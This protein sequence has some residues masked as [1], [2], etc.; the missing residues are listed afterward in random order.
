V[1]EDED[2]ED[3][4]EDEEDEEAQLIEALWSIFTALYSRGRYS[5]FVRST[6]AFGWSNE[7]DV[8][9]GRAGRARRIRRVHRSCIRSEFIARAFGWISIPKVIIV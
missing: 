7:F 1:R 3:E 5:Q 8:F 4:D 2:E 9:T 6:R